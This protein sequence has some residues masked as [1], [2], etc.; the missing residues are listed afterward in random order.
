MFQRY[1]KKAEL[2]LFPC[3][4]PSESLLLTPAVTRTL[5]RVWVSLPLLRTVKC[6]PLAWDWNWLGMAGGLGPVAAVPTIP[7]AAPAV[8]LCL[9]SSL[10]L[11]VP[12]VVSLSARYWE[13][14][15]G[16]ECGILLMLLFL[17]YWR[18][19]IAN[20][21]QASYCSPC[22]FLPVRVYI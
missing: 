2:L 22:F 20:Q 16:A 8:K 3:P 12:E 9:L 5:P 18:F 6:V 4:Y 15:T 19:C 7:Y 1:K 17:F 10:F 21:T 14:L 13:G 11:D